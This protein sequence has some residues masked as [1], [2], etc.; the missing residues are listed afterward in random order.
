MDSLLTTIA[1]PNV[2][3]ERLTQALR[4]LGPAT[5]PPSFWTKIANDAAYP[6]DQRRRA[7]FE[8]FVR[9]VTP[10]ETLGQLARQL[11]HPTWLYASDVTVIDR[12][13]GKIPV[14]WS[15]EDTIVAIAVFPDLPDGRYAHWAIY[16]KVSGKIERDSLVRVLL[17]EPT[18]A[19]VRDARLLEFGLS[20]PDPASTGD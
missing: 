15:P 9:H 19:A 14:S 4:H 16:L 2:S 11:D 3:R 17:G 20:P 6:P 18:G 12:L 10:G 8:L 5:E 13:G 1:D 7:V